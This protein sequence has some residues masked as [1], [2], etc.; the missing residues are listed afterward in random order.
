MSSSQAV[1]SAPVLELREYPR[2]VL[3]GEVVDPQQ[4]NSMKFDQLSM[5]MDAKL[6]L[7][8]NRYDVGTGLWLGSLFMIILGTP[9]GYHPFFLGLIQFHTRSTLNRA[10]HAGR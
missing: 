5:N 3:N 9:N 10:L 4:I 8:S 2:R 6:R 7:A 1:S